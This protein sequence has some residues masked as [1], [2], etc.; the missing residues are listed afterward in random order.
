MHHRLLRCCRT[1]VSLLLL[2]LVMM[3]LWTA[4]AQAQDSLSPAT[5]ATMLPTVWYLLAAGLA[6]LVPAG[7]VLLAVA[8]LEPQRAWNTALG[9]LAA[10]GLAAF[11]YWAIGFAIQFG[12]VGLVYPQAELRG[13]V[14]EWSPLSSEW[15]IGWGMSGL[16][17]W[18]LSGSDVTA[19]AYGLFLAHLP[20][21]ILATA[22]P[23]M[24]LR[25]RA[26]STVTLILAV[27]LGGVIYPL[28]GNWVQGGGWLNALGRN[29][30][31]GHGFVDFG[32]AGTVHLVAAG[33]TLAALTVWAERRA[34]QAP[35]DSIPPAHQPLLA[36]V[37][38]LLILGGGIG[39]QFA[40]PLQV[41][42][43]G[44]IGMMRGAV[45]SVLAAAGGLLFPLL[46]T[47]FV[48][49]GSEPTLTA[50]GFAAGVVA[51]LAVGPFVQPGVAFV[52]GLLAGATVPFVAYLLDGRMRLM[53]RT[54]IIV[55]SGAP[56]LIG[57][58]LVGLF[59]DGVAGN[60]WQATGQGSYLG[61][62]G[63]GVTGLLVGN[64]F[65][66]DFPG[67][68][69]AQVVGVAALALWGFLSG[70]IVCVP[71]G[72]I[73]HSLLHRQEEPAY[74]P[75]PRQPLAQPPVMQ[76]PYVPAPPQAPQIQTPNSAPPLRSLEPARPVEV[77]RPS[78]PPRTVG[79]PRTETAS[80]SEGYWPSQS[81]AAPPAHD[82]LP[83]IKPASPPE[84][85]RPDPVDPYQ[86]TETKPDVQSTS[87]NPP[88]PLGNGLSETEST[89]HDP[90]QNPFTRRR[91]E[92]LPPLSGDANQA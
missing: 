31:L 9:G 76:T 92:T 10:A 8:N 25:G 78:E 64:G 80:P 41:E 23:I 12:G 74:N 35:N 29:L 24:A 44:N 59:A 5:T 14:W 4:T 85:Y 11:A 51:G 70:L 65:Q 1:A 49:G 6:M 90:P 43:L 54:G 82:P 45:S 69:Q 56:A 21:V 62:T 2:V 71:L 22:L 48:T 75:L 89:H 72:L 50:R 57:L 84:A 46:Y 91:R 20:W 34:T 7:F 3:A 40:N 86:S 63:Q 47:W 42:T 61:V 81:L 13:L 27:A 28:A 73:F 30:T 15:G 88:K 53:D 60:G 39:W 67:Q 66:P 19:L 17:G 87:G 33:F 16:A 37:G 32:G 77:F 18:F 38:A 52:A 83:V 55:S 26:P 58:L 68:F 36:V 79:T